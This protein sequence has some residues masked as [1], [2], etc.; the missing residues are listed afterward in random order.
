MTLILIIIS[1]L[2]VGM[3]LGLLGAGGAILTVPALMLIAGLDE[4]SAVAHSLIIVMFIALAGSFRNLR[5]DGLLSF[6]ILSLFALC[7]IPFASIGAYVGSI[8]SGNAQMAALVTVMLIAS[9]RMLKKRQAMTDPEIKNGRLI[10]AGAGAGF[11]TGLVGVGGGFLIVPALMFFA[12]LTVKQAVANSLVL[13]VINSFIAFVTLH[14]SPAAP[15]IDLVLV[16]IM[17]AVGAAATYA[18]QRLA[19]L[20]PAERLQRVFAGLLVIVA[21]WVLISRVF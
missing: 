9:W 17:S 12:G 6:K 10:A 8:I 13:I 20:I 11:V 19:S 18:G 16:G 5:V 2:I 3:S 15:S 21:L 14:F 1:A 7:S 4:K